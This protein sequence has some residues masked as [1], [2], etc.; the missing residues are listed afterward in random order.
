MKKLILNS[1]EKALLAVLFKSS[2][3]SITR[4]LVEKEAEYWKL[5]NHQELIN[6]LLEK[7]MLR[8][9]NGEFVFTKAGLK[10]GEKCNAEFMKQGFDEGFLKHYKSKAY[11]KFCKEVYGTDMFL[12]SMINKHQI[13]KLEEAAD[14]KNTDKVLD[15]GCGPG[16]MLE[17]LFDKYFFKATGID[18]AP[19]TIQS[20]NERVKDKSG[21]K[22]LE[23]DIRNL[24]RL[25]KKF[26]KIIAVDS[27]YFNKDKEKTVGHIIGLLEENGSAFI[28]YTDLINSGRKK[29]SGI[30]ENL[31]LDYSKI[32]FTA[33]EKNHWLKT[34][35][36]AEKYKQEFENE[37][38][39]KIYEERISEAD[40][41]MKSE[42][43]RYLYVIKKKN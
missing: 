25:R 1:G 15:I 30:L 36:V 17:Y 4:E 6:S 18:F 2:N 19:G 13:E 20:A 27:L 38:N 33:E 5:E 26:T 43:E 37:N 8:E 39:L 28:F 23:M 42:Y 29:F 35:A 12:Y 10:E 34:K 41:V 11:R 9:L 21:I 24:N 40:D 7:S 16:E 22:Y 3:K 31:N 32:D 14:F